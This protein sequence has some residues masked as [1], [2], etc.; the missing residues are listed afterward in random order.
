M[1]NSTNI[2]ESLDYIQLKLLLESQIDSIINEIKLPKLK[3]KSLTPKER[4]KFYE[5]M[6]EF[7]NNVGPDGVI[8]KGYGKVTPDKLEKIYFDENERIKFLR[9]IGFSEEY[10]RENT[11]LMKRLFAGKLKLKDGLHLLVN[12]FIETFKKDNLLQISAGMI[13]IFMAISFSAVLIH[14]MLAIA[15]TSVIKFA[16]TTAMVSAVSEVLNYIMSKLNM[17][18]FGAISSTAL[19]VSVISAI[20]NT[21]VAP[22]LPLMFFG[23]TY[24]IIRLT[25]ILKSEIAATYSQ[26]GMNKHSRNILKTNTINAIVSSFLAGLH[27]QLQTIAQFTVYKILTGFV[28]LKL[29]T[30]NTLSTRPKLRK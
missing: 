27:T 14:L 13:V 3:D 2:S 5:V 6:K 17:S 25:N 26:V 16:I 23:I 12:R 29:I 9:A 22:T 18:V 10:I 7:L 30:K 15:T 4:K 28:S 21:V 8:V 1:I 24:I 20:I 19:S 11:E